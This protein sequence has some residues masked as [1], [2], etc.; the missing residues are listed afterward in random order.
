MKPRGGSPPDGVTSPPLVSVVTPVYNGADYLAECIESVLAQTYTSWEY[1]IID[2]CSTDDTNR[3]AR[4]YA[5]TDDRIRV[6]RNEKLLSAS[7][8]ANRCM[9]AISAA[10]KY[11]KM[12]HADDF[13]FPRCLEEMVAVAERHPEVGIVCSYRLQGTRIL[14]VGLPYQTQIVPGHEACRMNLVDGPYTLGSP[15][16]HLLRSEIVRGR[17][18]FYDE[19]HIAEDVEAD[20]EVLEGWDL[21]FVHQVLVFSRVHDASITATNAVLRA[22]MANGFYLLRKFGPRHL[23]DAEMKAL[24]RRALRKYYRLL[25]EDAVRGGLP[26]GYWAFHKE[27]LE[28]SGLRLNPGRVAFG[29]ARAILRRIAGRAGSDPSTRWP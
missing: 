7:A 6:V 17:R 28:R 9:E 27:T 12:L 2:N 16:A 10:S 1:V 3:I 14:S 19:T 26:Q 23:D 5:E 24:T 15:S 18:P 8:N 11:T 13:M 4:R 20:F 25:G 21:G 22:E 29:A